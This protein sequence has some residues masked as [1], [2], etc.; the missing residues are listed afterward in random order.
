[1]LV[2]GAIAVPLLHLPCSF[3]FFYSIIL[4]A[5][6]MYFALWGKKC[7]FVRNERWWD[8][9]VCLAALLLL[10]FLHQ[11]SSAMVR[12]YRA[13]LTVGI[14]FGVSKLFGQSTR[15]K[16]IV[17]PTFFVYCAHSI[18]IKLMPLAHTPHTALILATSV[19]VALIGVAILLKRLVPTIYEFLAAGR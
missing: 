10:V 1:M 13:Y 11:S 3:S 14:S 2:G 6:G 15:T 18:V 9:T 19:F 4:F 7:A 8:G 5:A 16:T 17:L 12:M